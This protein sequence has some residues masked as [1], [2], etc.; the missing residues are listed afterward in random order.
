MTK[1]Q[2]PTAPTDSPPRTRAKTNWLLEFGISLGLAA[3]IAVVWITVSGLWNPGNWNIPQGYTG[4]GLQI[5]GWIHAAAEGEYHF[6]GPSFVERLGAPF[7]ANWNDY[8]MYEK[9]F[10][11][12]LGYLARAIGTFAAVN[13]GMLLVHVFATMSFYL[14]CRRFRWCRWWSAV[15]ALIFGLQYY[16]SFRGQGHL[17]LSLIYTLPLGISTIWILFGSRRVGT[18]SS[19]RFWCVT[20]SFL[21]G[22]SSPYFLNM[23]LQ[24]LLITVALHF[25]IHRRKDN[26][27]TAGLS[28][29]ASVVAFLVAHNGMLLIRYMSGPNA[30][31]LARKVK[32]SEIYAF[33]PIELFLPFPGHRSEF[34]GAFGKFYHAES[35]YQQPESL[36]AYLGIIGIVILL[37]LLCATLRELVRNRAHR[38]PL[39]FWLSG[40]VLVY[41]IVGGVNYGFA[42]LGIRMFRATNRYSVVIATMLLLWAVSQLHRRRLRW[43]RSLQFAIGVGAVLLAIWDQLPSSPRQHRA[44]VAA[45]VNLDADFGSLVQEVL[46]AGAMV[47]QLPAADFPEGAQIHGMPPYEHLRPYFHT[48]DM[49]FSFGSNR[50]RLDAAWQFSLERRPLRE[51][52]GELRRFGFHAVIIHK[53]GYADHADSLL[54]NLGAMGLQPMAV[55]E[56]HD[57]ALVPL[58]PPNP[59]PELP[60]LNNVMILNYGSGWSRVDLD[61]NRTLWKVS[62]WSEFEL[63]PNIPIGEEL[64]LTLELAAAQP[65]ELRVDLV[66]KELARTTMDGSSPSSITVSFPRPDDGSKLSVSVATDDWTEKNK[67]LQFAVTRISIVRN[68][69]Q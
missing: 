1:D 69:Q 5:L 7:G 63:S 52:I 23:Y 15:G 60:D 18:G 66:G 17:L 13:A 50:G 47:F 49:R 21:L 22:M 4:D 24:L 40:W 48:D 68:P 20:V 26:L 37:G 57:L 54:T 16:I 65:M 36:S 61:P 43:S 32:E 11:I 6:F 62:A 34:F 44:E 29:V 46:P 35:A 27:V 41:S 2:P 45:K 25:M 58:P 9:P 28:L 59:E 14:V 67:S 53:A 51:M 3:L 56:D 31:A 30:G 8:P 42:L 33:R 12:M 55:A 19:N 38:V 39:A 64:T 10:T